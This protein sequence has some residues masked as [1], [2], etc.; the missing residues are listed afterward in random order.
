MGGLRVGARA[1]FISL[2]AR[3]SNE[4]KP[5]YWL[6]ATRNVTVTSAAESNNLAKVE[7]ARARL[8]A[9]FSVRAAPAN[10]EIRESTRFDRSTGEGENQSANPQIH[11]S[12]ATRAIAIVTSGLARKT[13]TKP[14]SRNSQNDVFRFPFVFRRTFESRRQTIRIARVQNRFNALSSPSSV[15]SWW[16]ERD[17][18][19][20]L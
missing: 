18:E 6:S 1:R 7:C 9:R 19:M 10:F 12:W 4:I 3:L 2:V 14:S 17:A 16:R 13:G 15:A 20:D 11:P 8:I 5:L